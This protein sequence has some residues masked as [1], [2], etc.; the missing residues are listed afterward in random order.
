MFIKKDLRK[1][2]RI[3]EDAA[4]EIEDA[5]DDRDDDFETQEQ[6]VTKKRN[7]LTDLCLAR[8]PA[9]FKGSLNILCQPQNGPSLRHLVNLSVYDCQISSLDGIGMLGSPVDGGSVCSPALETLN[10]GR[11]PITS[12]P[13]ELSNLKGSLKELWADDCQISGPIPK[14]ILELQLLATLQ[15]SNNKIAAIPAGIGDLTNLQILCLDGNELTSVP[16]ELSKLHKLKSLLLRY[17]PS[18]LP[19]HGKCA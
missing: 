7:F 10:V 6:H 16:S 3:L 5:I 12:L 14:C 8:R 11:N 15:M 9:E 19:E 4:H 1:I 17:V 18:S 2:P 13:D